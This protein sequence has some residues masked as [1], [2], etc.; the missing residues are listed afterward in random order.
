MSPN[1]KITRSARRTRS[2]TARPLPDGSIEVLAPQDMSDAEL[3]PIIERLTKRLARRAEKRTLSDAD[4]AQR[5]RDLNK[6]Y[7]GGRLLHA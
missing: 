2:I 1:V 7:F 3:T 6:K 4:L 5:A